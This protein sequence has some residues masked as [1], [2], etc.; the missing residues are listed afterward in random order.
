MLERFV[1]EVFHTRRQSRGYYASGLFIDYDTTNTSSYRVSNNT[2]GLGD[3][4]PI[5]VA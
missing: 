4:H 1:V 3:V 5:D 2:V